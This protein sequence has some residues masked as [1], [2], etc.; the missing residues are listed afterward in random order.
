MCGV[1]SSVSSLSSMDCTK[2]KS[3][4]NAENPKEAKVVYQNEQNTHDCLADH[5]RV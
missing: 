3:E 4:P 5:G 2:P 1:A